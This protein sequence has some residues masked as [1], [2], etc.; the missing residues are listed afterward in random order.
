MLSATMK[1]LLTTLLTALLLTAGPGL[2]GLQFV[3]DKDPKHSSPV[4]VL[5]ADEL[6][7]LRPIVERDLKEVVKR[8]YNEDAPTVADLDQIFNG[9]RLIKFNLGKLGRA[10]LVE[11]IGLPVRNM[12]MLNVYVPTKKSYRVVVAASGFGP[13]LLP[14]K[15]GIPDLVFGGSSGLG[16]EKLYRYHYSREKRKYELNACDDHQS[17][18]LVCRGEDLP[19][20]PDP[21]S[22]DGDG[23]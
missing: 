8:V 7:R 1:R 3:A 14:N 16:T 17:E 4:E 20:F 22:Q 13:Y 2:A 23:Q 12:A 21:L 6:S 5:S 9:C 18:N 19:T 10:I 11:G 15:I